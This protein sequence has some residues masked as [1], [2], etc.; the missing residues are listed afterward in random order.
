M[1]IIKAWY[2]AQLQ[3]VVDVNI[4]VITMVDE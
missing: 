1:K 3:Y 4:Y 2:N